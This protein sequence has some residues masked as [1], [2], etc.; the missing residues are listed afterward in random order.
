MRSDFAPE[1]GRRKMRTHHPVIEQ[2]S[3][4]RRERKFPPQRQAGK[5]RLITWQMQFQRRAGS[6]KA[7]TPARELRDCLRRFEPQDR[8]VGAPG[9]EPGTR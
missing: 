5:S 3:A 7:P 2:V 4:L 6:E 9:L 1:P 8:V